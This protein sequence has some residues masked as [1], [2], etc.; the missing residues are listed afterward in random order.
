MFLFHSFIKVG[1]SPRENSSHAGSWRQ[2]MLHRVVTP[3]KNLKVTGTEYMSPLRNPHVSTRKRTRA[4]L[5]ELWRVAIKQTIILN[6]MDKENARLQ[7]RQ[8]QIK[9]NEIKRIKLEYDEISCCDQQAVE[10]WENFLSASSAEA[11]HTRKDPKVLYQAIKNGVPRAKRGEIWKFLANQHSFSTPPVDTTDFPNY[12]TPYQTLLKNLT[13][14]QHAIF[15]DLGEFSRVRRFS[16]L[17]SPLILNSFSSGR[18]FPDHKYYK[19]ALGVGQLSLFNLLKAYSI[20]DPELG[21]CQGLGFI[22]AV[23]LLHVSIVLWFDF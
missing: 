9:T 2:A 1:N 7:A 3:S 19:D 10:I 6:R 5:R 14:H 16:G 21:Y 4:E 12:N 18:T 8:N 15:I 20:L 17:K 23:L 13:E 22:C 11:V